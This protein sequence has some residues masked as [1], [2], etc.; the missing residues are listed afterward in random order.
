MEFDDDLQRK[1][2][3][4]GR[5]PRNYVMLLVL[6]LLALTILWQGKSVVTGGGRTAEVSIEEYLDYKKNKLVKEVTVGNLELEAK[7]E[8]GFVR[9][10]RSYE[11]IQ[12]SFPPAFVNHPDG[13]KQLFEGLDPKN[14]HY[15]QS[16][17]F[18]Q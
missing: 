1:D 10:D 12:C 17:K 18:F 4:R 11:K 5:R 15:E 9:G 16:D 14:F 13:I 8:A 2:E 6:A 7:M 3:P